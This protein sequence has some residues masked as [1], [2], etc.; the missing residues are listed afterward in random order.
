[1]KAPTIV[2]LFKNVWI[3]PQ[4][5][6]LL[7]SKVWTLKLYG[8]KG[9]TNK[10]NMMCGL[11]ELEVL[12]VSCGVCFVNKQHHNPIPEKSEWCANKI[13]DLI[14]AYFCRPEEPISH[15]GKR[16]LLCFIDDY[17][18]ICFLKSQMPRSVSRLTRN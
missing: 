7:A 4:T 17:S 12:N 13:F 11:P 8:I 5:S 18:H 16:D 14:H 15:S 6:L 2:P 1:M 10:K 9:A 3:L